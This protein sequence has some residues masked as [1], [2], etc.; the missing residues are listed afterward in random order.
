MGRPPSCAARRLASMRACSRPP[1]TH[2]LSSLL[3]QANAGE[4]AK[5]FRLQFL[6]AHGCHGSLQPP[7]LLLQ[8]SGSFSIW[9][10]SSLAS[11]CERHRAPAWHLIF[12]SPGLLAAGSI[13]ELISVLYSC[14][15]SSTPYH[16]APPAPRT[17]LYPCAGHICTRLT[18]SAAELHGCDR[19]I[20]GLG[21]LPAR[22]Q[23]P[24]PPPART[25]SARGTA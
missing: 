23:D 14:R 8:R 18:N 25:G 4:E 20:G 12:L 16:R 1:K 24:P 3:R 17:L 22:R 10:G 6:A 21:A 2:S 7:S 13:S 15:S 5:G 19:Q 11:I 9:S